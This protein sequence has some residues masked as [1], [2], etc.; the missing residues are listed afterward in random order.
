MGLSIKLGIGL[1]IGLRTTIRQ[2]QSIGLTGTPW[3]ETNPC[4]DFFGKRLRKGF[5]TLAHYVFFLFFLYQ[6]P[7]LQRWGTPKHCL[8]KTI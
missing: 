2:G 1:G 5:M 8:L 4:G 7:D 6:A 3:M